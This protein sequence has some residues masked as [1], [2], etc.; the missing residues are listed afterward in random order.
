M[1]QQRLAAALRSLTL[2]RIL[3]TTCSL[4]LGARLDC[5]LET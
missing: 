2:L 5:P 3:V 1:R 4:C